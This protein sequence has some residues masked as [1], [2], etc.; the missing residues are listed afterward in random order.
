MGSRSGVNYAIDTDSGADIDFSNT[1]RFPGAYPP[2]DAPRWKPS[3]VIS[4]FQSGHGFTT[5]GTFASSDLNHTADFVLGSQSIKV[6]TSAGA[7]G[8]VRRTGLTAVDVSTSHFRVWVKCDSPTN[9]SNLTLYLGTGGFAAFKVAFFNEAVKLADGWMQVD[10]NLDGASTTGSPD[11]TAITDWQIRVIDDGTPV[12]VFLNGIAIIERPDP[13]PVGVVSITFDDSHDTDYTEAR[14]KLDEYDYPATSYVLVPRI[15][16]AN[17]LT[18]AQLHDLQDTHGWEIGGHAY[19]EN[20]HG[21][22][23]VGF[24]GLSAAD[25]DD[26]LQNLKSWLLSNGFANPD[27]LAYPQ[28]DVDADVES[29]VRKYFRS[30]RYQVTRP[31]QV[32]PSARPTLIRADGVT[33]SDDATSLNALVDTAY[34]NR[35]WM[36]FNFHKLVAAPSASTEFSISEFST[37]VDY[38]NTKG[39]PVMTVGQVF[40]AGA[41]GS[42][43]LPVGKKVVNSGSDTQSG[44]GADTTF[45]IAHGLI[46]APSYA[47]V[48]PGSADAR[49]DHFHVTVDATNIT[50]TYA[51]A[52]ASGTNNLTWYWEARV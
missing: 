40:R 38:L 37:F 34:D 14:K 29:A 18:L 22:S 52:P 7:T 8:N 45:T 13:F 17:R 44:D 28:G 9:L 3:Q 20:A 35:T 39:I 6:T 36:I 23:G 5:T 4:A 1:L 31:R 32:W 24:S 46:S 48:Q 41:Q 10:F 19:T 49:A 25:L 16:T 51:N 43:V 42:P 12:T 30:G 15:G 47:N 2:A 33:S 27:H 26:E 11:L 50:I 21:A